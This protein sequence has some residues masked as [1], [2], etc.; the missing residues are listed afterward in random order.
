M[1]T[2][3]FII[4][5]VLGTR[6]AIIIADVLVLILTWRKT[7]TTQR[8]ASRVGI[9]TP[10]SK[11]LLRDGAHLF[12]DSD[13]VVDCACNAGTI[14]FV[15]VLNLKNMHIGVRLKLHTAFFWQ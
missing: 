10:L 3:Y 11:L 1:I 12:F 2:E 5:V 15:C 13:L 4:S 8:D 9:R 6:L 7:F 14:Y